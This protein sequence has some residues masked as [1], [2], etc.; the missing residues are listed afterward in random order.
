MFESIIEEKNQMDNEG[1]C[2][3]KLGGRGVGNGTLLGERRIKY[4]ESRI[5]RSGIV[6]G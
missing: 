2:M 3:T 1:K 6:Y 5:A 4:R